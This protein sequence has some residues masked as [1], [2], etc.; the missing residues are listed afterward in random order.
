MELEEIIEDNTINSETINESIV[1]D[2]MSDDNFNNEQDFSN[3][4]LNDSVNM[5][6]NTSNNQMKLI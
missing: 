2:E 4:E 1:S 5:F 3:I 6:S